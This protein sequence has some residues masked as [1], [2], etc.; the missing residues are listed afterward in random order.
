MF[1]KRKAPESEKSEPFILK[2]QSLEANHIKKTPAP[3]RYMKSRSQQKKMH[4]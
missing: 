2:S 1:V 4:K 3:M